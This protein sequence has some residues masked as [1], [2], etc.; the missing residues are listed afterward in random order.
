MVNLLCVAFS[1]VMGIV[2]FFGLLIWG[3]D[4]PR[5]KACVVI[6]VIVILAVIVL[7]ICLLSSWLASKGQSGY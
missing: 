2:A 1:V 4:S 7:S 6:A 5:E 3:E